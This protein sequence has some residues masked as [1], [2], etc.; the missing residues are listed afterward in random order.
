V[1]VELAADAAAPAARGLLVLRELARFGTLLES[2]P[3]EAELRQ[4]RGALRLQAS[5]LTAEAPARVEAA[6]GAMADV[7]SVS[8]AVASRSEATRPVSGEGGRTVRVRTELLDRFVD[9][10]GELITHRYMLQAAAQQERWGEVREGIDQLR[11]LVGDLHHHVLQVRMMPLE[12]ITGRLPRLVRDLCRKSG[13][14]VRLR[15]EGEKIEL[16]R[17][18][19]EELAD[20]LIHMV[21][22][23]VDHGI[24][25]SGTVT[26]R[27]RREKD[28]ALLE[29]ADDGRGIDPAAIRRKAVEKGLLTPAQAE[30]LRDRDALLLVCAPGFSTAAE[31]TETSGRGVGMDVV[32][33]AVES[34]GGTLAIDSAVGAGTRIRLRLPLSV[35]IIQVLLVE[36]AGHTLGLPVTR[37]RRTLELERAQVRAGG[38]QVVADL[39]GETVPLVPL[40][41]MLG[42]PAAVPRGTLP[43]VLSEHRGRSLGLVVDRLVGQREVFVKSLAFPL[44]RLAGVGGA[45]VL[46]DG[47]VVFIIDPQALVEERLAAATVL[48]PAGA[49]P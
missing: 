11:R 39:D 21:R 29:V 33:S 49:P 38:R 16:D 20:P 41:K 47:S 17:A 23:A 14:E 25:R 9:L 35:A 26:V 8:V 1:T 5:L 40:G 7:A 28:L 46:G 37:V 31:V 36:C 4:G 15:V 13:K 42:L 27:A 44:D 3:G 10:A 43:V 18:I 6:V 22:N 2:A 19:L 12:S 24:A 48:R 45:T 34:L 32:K 30:R